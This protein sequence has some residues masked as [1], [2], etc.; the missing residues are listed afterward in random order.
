MLTVT[1]EE[2]ARILG[3]TPGMV[4]QLVMKGKLHPL[5][6]KARPLRFRKSEILELEMSRRP[7]SESDWLDRLSQEWE[8]G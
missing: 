7:Q 1:T 5:K 8:E 3:V 6:P 2:A 4:R